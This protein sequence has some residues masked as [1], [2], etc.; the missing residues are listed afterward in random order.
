ML[1]F[2]P[3][4]KEKR[5]RRL[6]KPHPSHSSF[7]SMNIRALQSYVY[8]FKYPFEV[9]LTSLAQ[10]NFIVRRQWQISFSQCLT[11]DT[12]NESSLLISNEK[13]TMHKTELWWSILQIGIQENTWLN[14]TSQS[15]Y[16]TDYSFPSS[17]PL[18]CNTSQ[19]LV[20]RFVLTSSTV[21]V[22]IFWAG[23]TV[24]HKLWIRLKLWCLHSSC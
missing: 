23:L 13:Q 1:H 19:R 4:L 17:L 16:R 12:D 5:Q 14:Y 18:I 3:E 7:R 8:I 9:T 6:C 22:H 2:S 21:H 20:G 10:R 11:N 15:M 24:V